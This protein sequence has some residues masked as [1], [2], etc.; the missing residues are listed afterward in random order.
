MNNLQYN[1]L[2]AVVQL[3]GCEA[4]HFYFEGFCS[5][6]HRFSILCLA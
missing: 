4:A 2:I 5:F 3:A 1:G 6:R